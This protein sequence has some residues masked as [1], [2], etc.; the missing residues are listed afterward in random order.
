MPTEPASRQGTAPGASATAGPRYE[1]GTA[2]AP[3]AEHLWKGE[4]G[5]TQG[6]QLLKLEVIICENTGEA[7]VESR[8]V[9]PQRAK[10]IADIQARLVDLSAEVVDGQVM[11][12][13]TL[14]KQI[15]FVGDDDRVHHVAEDVPF[16]V[17]VDCVGTTPDMNAQVTAR[18]AKLS[19]H[20]EYCQELVQQAVLQLSVKVTQDAQVNVVL[21]A[22]GPLVKAEA[23]VGENNT[24]CPVESVTELDRPAIKV[25]DVRVT[26]DDVDAEVAEGQ[27][28]IQGTLIQ[29]IFFI[30]ASNEE[31][32]QE[33]RVPFTCI[34][35]V[36]GAMPGDNVVLRPSILRVDRFLTN[37]HLVRQR[38]ILQAFA[39]VTQTVDVHVAEDPNGPLV[40]AS[41]VTGTGSRQVLVENECTL[42]PPAQK[43]QEIQARVEDLTTE[44]ILNKVLVTGTLHK[45]IFYVGPDDVVHHQGEDV[46]FTTFVDLPGAKPGDSA[47]VIPRVEHVSWQ[48]DGEVEVEDTYDPYTDTSEVELWESLHQK[49][50]IEL[51]VR[52]AEDQEIRVATAA[53]TGMVL[54]VPAATM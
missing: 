42:D 31:Y 43:I 32:F 49:T 40:L 47:T 23:V 24:V 38:V 21:N 51:V 5:L 25:R 13:G 15:F 22:T 35:A 33:E 17:F 41:R 34:A 12:Q 18:I 45:Q 50:I 39:R 2:G 27:V 9:L 10:K 37:G 48:L 53:I 46:K 7:S 16:N 30:A 14:H 36:P 52:V 28:L 6:T 20:L 54:G 1:R 4:T 3:P 44:I 26:L 29:S 11:V 19:H 8:L